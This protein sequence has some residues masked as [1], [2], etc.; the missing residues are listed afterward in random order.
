VAVSTDSDHQKTA[1]SQQADH[2]ETTPQ[3]ARAVPHPQHA[4]GKP[5]RASAP[6]PDD[7]GMADEEVRR[8]TAAPPRKE[9]DRAL[10]RIARG[11]G[12]HHGKRADGGDARHKQGR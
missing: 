1:A 12:D 5:L 10:L 8:S 11:G 9:R 6:R 3:T 7:Q 2:A 4:E